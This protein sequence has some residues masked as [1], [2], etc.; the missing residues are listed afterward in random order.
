MT[1]TRQLAVSP[2]ERV[3]DEGVSERQFGKS[4]SRVV[5]AA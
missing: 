3:L 5:L 4:L 2:L 1:P